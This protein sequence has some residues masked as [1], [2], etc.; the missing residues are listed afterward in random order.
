MPGSC[1]EDWEWKLQSSEG[2]KKPN[3]MLIS[4]TETCE[5][6]QQLV[7]VQYICK[8]VQDVRKFDKECMYLCENCFLRIG[9]AGWRES[10]KKSKNGGQGR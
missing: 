2:M 4:Q 6:C 5:T 7:P 10:E 8:L 9:I 3:L 1:G